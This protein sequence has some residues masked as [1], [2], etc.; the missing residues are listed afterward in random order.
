MHPQSKGEAG[1][2]WREQRPE[3]T[4]EAGQQAQ[5]FCKPVPPG[6]AQGVGFKARGMLAEGSKQEE[7]RG[8][9]LLGWCAGRT[10]HFEANPP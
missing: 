10:L 7:R 6:L 3:I 1:H 5:V 4:G 9:G 2:R 8:A